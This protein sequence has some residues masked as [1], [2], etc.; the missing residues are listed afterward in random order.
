VS[1]SSITITVIASGGSGKRRRESVK[2]QEVRFKS[3]GFAAVDQLKGAINHLLLDHS[4]EGFPL[5]LKLGKLVA[6]WETGWLLSFVNFAEPL[7]SF[8]IMATL[9]FLQDPWDYQRSSAR[10][11]GV[12]WD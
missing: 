3:G 4:L 7:N 10:S 9:A 11:F 12:I 2:V 1:I 8:V 6:S 5:E